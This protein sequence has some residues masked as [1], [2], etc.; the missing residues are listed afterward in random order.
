M[1]R[2]NGRSTGLVLLAG[3]GSWIAWALALTASE[4]VVTPTRLA[5]ALSGVLISTGLFGLVLYRSWTYQFPGGEGAG[6]AAVGSLSF[7][8]GQG[9]VLLR[10][11][12]ALSTWFVAP[13]VL[14]LVG[15]SVLLAVGLVRARRTPPWL[16]VGLLV[17]SVL[18]L[19]FN[20]LQLL[21]IP[22]G[23]VWVAIGGHLWRHP[24]RPTDHLEPSAL[25]RS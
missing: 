19:G 12:G 20:R 16:G 14:A 3:G 10:G 13:G 24:E 21:A 5:I 4:Q 25:G 9:I 18:F 2:A 22:L 6:L 11:E 23:L 17:G 7:A 1:E 15:G 8:V